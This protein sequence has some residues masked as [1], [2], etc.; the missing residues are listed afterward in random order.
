MNI[1]GI[2]KLINESRSWFKGHERELVIT[3]RKT[4]QNILVEFIYRCE[5]LDAFNVGEFVKIDI[6]L[7]G[8]EWTNK[9]GETN[10]SIQGW[11]IEKKK[12]KPTVIY[13]P[14][15]MISI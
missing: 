6:N 13:H 9:D 1:S 15:R 14:F 8:R 10:I 3:L 5:I 7:R 4:S 12:I 11:R 2:I